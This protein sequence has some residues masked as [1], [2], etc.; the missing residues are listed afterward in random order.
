MLAGG[1]ISGM[2]PKKENGGENGI[3][4]VMASVKGGEAALSGEN[5]SI[6]ESMAASKWRQRK[7]TAARRR[8]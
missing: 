3:G 8:Q 6:E 4:G 1:E 7:I 2:K 5:G